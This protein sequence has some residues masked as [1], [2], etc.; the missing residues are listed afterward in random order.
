MCG[1][2]MTAATRCSFAADVHIRAI[3]AN[4][5]RPGG[6]P[7]RS[8]ASYCPAETNGDRCLTDGCALDVP[9]YTRAPRQAPHRRRGGCLGEVRLR[10]D[11]AIPQLHDELLQAVAGDVAALEQIGVR[12]RHL[13]GR[14]EIGKRT[15]VYILDDRLLV[16]VVY[17]H[18]LVDA[19]AV[20][21]GCA[22][23][24][25]EP[26]FVETE[27]FLSFFFY[28]GLRF[29]RCVVG[30]G[31]RRR[32]GRHRRELAAASDHARQ[33]G[34]HQHVD[35]LPHGFAGCFRADA[36]QLLFVLFQKL[37]A[38][39]FDRRTLFFDDSVD[40][41]FDVEVLNPGQLLQR[42]PVV[43]PVTTR[44]YEGA[45]DHESHEHIL[46]V[47]CPDERHCAI[48]KFLVEIQVLVHG[49]QV[50]RLEA[51]GHHAKML[52]QCRHQQRVVGERKRKV[53]F[54]N[55]AIGVAV[56]ELLDRPVVIG[57]RV[58]TKADS[59][60]GVIAAIRIDQY[61]RV[62]ATFQCGTRDKPGVQ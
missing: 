8:P 12:N 27:F 57:L 38:F 47:N 33:I 59:F 16:I 37:F 9:R 17:K 56:L 46:I 50:G 29:S 10:F 34:A 18:H 23:R 52:M 45:G 51:S 32:C 4:L 1:R 40:R 55:F 60:R 3:C 53:H 54:G 7:G 48:D 26:G 5:Y 41:L 35:K 31:L 19:H 43:Q 15:G 6:V 20:V 13:V 21:T 39:S 2:N 58:T 30:F 11:T 36:F 24:C 28:P 14:H 49:N 25:V 62:G 44:K 42:A 22:H 61:E